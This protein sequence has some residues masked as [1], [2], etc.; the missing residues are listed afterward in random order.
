MPTQTWGKKTE[1]NRKGRDKM[2]DGDRRTDTGRERDDY[3]G[4]DFTWRIKEMHK[5]RASRW[6][7]RLVELMGAHRVG[8]CF[9]LCFLLWHREE[10][11]Y[12]LISRGRDSRVNQSLAAAPAS[13]DW[14]EWA[15]DIFL[16][17]SWD[18]SLWEWHEKMDIYIS[19]VWALRTEKEY[20]S[21]AIKLVAGGDAYC[22]TALI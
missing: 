11:W 14:S 18:C 1:K 19:H 4:A 15:V 3:L 10:L 6:Q 7:V 16:K 21:L 12:F 8:V 13:A 20:L 17:H 22:S 5:E 9:N 2:W